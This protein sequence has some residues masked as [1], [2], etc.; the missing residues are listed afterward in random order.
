MSIYQKPNSWNNFNKNASLVQLNYINVYLLKLK[1]AIM[2]KEVILA[3]GHKFGGHCGGVAVIERFNQ[4]W[5]NG[6]SAEVKKVDV[7]G[8]GL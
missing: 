4:E 8:A 1:M 7:V 2:W 6:L 3:V 5:T